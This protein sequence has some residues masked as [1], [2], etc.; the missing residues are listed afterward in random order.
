MKTPFDKGK[1]NGTAFEYDKV[2]NII[3]IWEYSYGVLKK[4]EII[5]RTDKSGEKQGVWKDFFPSGKEKSETTYLNGKKTG[6][7]KTFLESG[8]LGNIERYVGDSLQMETPELTTKLEV[9]NEYYEDGSIK[10]TG[11]YLYGIAEG[12]HKEYSPDRKITGAKI[13]HEGNLI[14]EGLIDEAGKIGRAHV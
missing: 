7:S 11:T 14:G 1:E 8:S 13:Y 4:Q 9:R 3:T 10:K 5:N 12:T 6:Y 2:G